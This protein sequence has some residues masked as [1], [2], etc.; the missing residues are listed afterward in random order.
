MA[1]GNTAP[2]SG[3]GLHGEHWG[4]GRSASRDAA[5]W[6]QGVE[7][8]DL[9]D[10]A[11]P[12][13]VQARKAA[14]DIENA[15]EEARKLSAPQS[16]SG[17]DIRMERER[18]HWRDHLPE[19]THR[20]DEVLSMESRHVL[21]AHAGMESGDDLSLS[22]GPE[23]ILKDEKNLSRSAP[24]NEKQPQSELGMGMQFKLGF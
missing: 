18:S 13:E 19:G 1:Q 14:T 7:A 5:L 4:F 16:S 11:L 3:R 10:H 15:L 22:V 12:P 20:P 8:Q 24:S 21:K 2:D 17:L 6:Q 9:Y 23:L